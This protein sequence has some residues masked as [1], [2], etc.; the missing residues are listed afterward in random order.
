LKSINS[1]SIIKTVSELSIKANISLREDVKETLYKCVEIEENSLSRKM[2]E[3]LIQNAK[4]AKG[5][6]LPICQ[7]TGMVVVF[8]E[9]GRGVE[10]DFSKLELDIN[11]GVTNAY[12]E[13][14]FRKSIVDNPISRINTNDNSP[15]VIHYDFVE[16]QG[17]KITVLVKGFGAENKSKLSMLNPT[18]SE[19]EIINCVVD[20]VKET[21]P[22]ACPPYVL[23]IGIGGTFDK[24]ALLS[25]KALLRDINKFSE[26]SQIAKLEN[27]I[28]D[29]VNDLKIGVM[30]LGGKCTCLGV[31]IL[32]YPTHIAGLPLA[33]NINCH[34]LR[35]ASKKI[36]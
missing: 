17:L 18:V 20:I 28:L 12:K 35:S 27:K 26:D 33:V 1:K 14:F 31:N 4:I 36:M 25:K 29:K 21:G 15:A 23:G 3:Y 2:L 34:A 9:I 5:K 16:R 32:T 10:L 8:V 24:A 7:D 11:K 13:G 30:G 6:S 19:E 22:D